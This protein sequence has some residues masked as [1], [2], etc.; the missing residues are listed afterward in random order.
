ML[1]RRDPIDVEDVAGFSVC[2]G[3]APAC[4][5][6]VEEGRRRTK[7]PVPVRLG[8][9]PSPPTSAGSPAMSPATPPSWARRLWR[10]I[11]AAP[12]CLLAPA[13]IQDS[14]RELLL[15]PRR[16]LASDPLDRVEADTA[17]PLFARR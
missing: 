17:P 8:A 7:T 3:A 14:R 6:A 1:L 5:L 10:S 2:P 12:G 16:P 11:A 15:E 9:T 4:K 13:R